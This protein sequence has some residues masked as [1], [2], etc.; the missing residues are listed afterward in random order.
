MGR[1]VAGIIIAFVFLAAPA[2]AA[3]VQVTTTGDDLTP[4]D[5]TCSLREAINTLEGSSNLDCGPGG[6]G[7]TIQLGAG[8]YILS[9]PQGGN[10]DANHTGDL[11]LLGNIVIQ[12][13]G[14]GS[15]TIDA[16]HVDRV[17]DVR[18][19]ATVTIDAVTITGGRAPSGAPVAPVNGGAGSDA[20]G[21]IAN[22]GQGGGGIRSSGSL[23]ISNSVVTD[24]AAGAGS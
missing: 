12:G 22:A 16:Q 10:N 15:T 13:V 17:F 7:G 20:T 18:P 4:A 1:I 11:D 3:V 5:G 2:Q 14:A 23:T 9:L 8:H 21:Q 6:G 19:G 24:N